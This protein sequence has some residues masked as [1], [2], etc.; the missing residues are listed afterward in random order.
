MR[1]LLRFSDFC[2]K[3]VVLFGSLQFYAVV[4]CLFTFFYIF[5]AAAPTPEEI[6]RLWTCGLITSFLNFIPNSTLFSCS[7]ASHDVGYDTSW[8]FL[9]AVEC[10]LSEL[11]CG[12]LSPLSPSLLYLPNL[13]P[14]DLSYSNIQSYF[15]DSSSQENSSSF[16]VFLK[17]INFDKYQLLSKFPLISC[18]FQ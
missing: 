15:S 4:K 8:V 9:Y 17:I 12:H 18:C 13:L 3:C 2:L 1:S 7:N 11:S 10:S 5:T 16:V 14:A 6:W